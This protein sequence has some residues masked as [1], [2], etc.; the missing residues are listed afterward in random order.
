[1]MWA[2]IHV[3]LENLEAAM[4]WKRRAAY[5]SITTGLARVSAA[6]AR[7]R[8]DENVRGVCLPFAPIAPR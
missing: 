3:I 6:Q 4:H 2:S 5:A 7:A 8:I 1:M